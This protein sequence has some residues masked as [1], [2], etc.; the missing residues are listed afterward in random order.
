MKFD[1]AG[2]STAD[3]DA[4]WEALRAE[5]AKRECMASFGGYRCQQDGRDGHTAHSWE[6]TSMGIQVTWK[7]T[8]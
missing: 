3:L 7:M 6:S 2:L 5:T 8:A 4:A 1:Y